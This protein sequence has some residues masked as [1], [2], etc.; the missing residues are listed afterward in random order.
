ML[1]AKYGKCY[2]KT[3]RSIGYQTAEGLTPAERLEP[4]LRLHRQSARICTEVLSGV[5]CG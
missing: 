5:T 4:V 2:W 3:A 1:Y